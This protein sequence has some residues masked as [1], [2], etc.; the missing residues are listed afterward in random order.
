MTDENSAKD[1]TNAIEQAMGM[2][3]AADH[4]VMV[5]MPRNMG[6]HPD[7]PRGHSSL[8]AR[9]DSV[10]EWDSGRFHLLKAKTVRPRAPSVIIAGIRQ[11]GL[12][13]DGSDLRELESA[14][15]RQDRDHADD[16]RSLWMILYS[17]CS[18]HSSYTLA[19]SAMEDY[20]GD[21]RAVIEQSE[22]PYTKN[23]CFTAII[24]DEK[25]VRR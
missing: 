7:A 1:V 25:G 6:G 4:V 14:F 3:D 21:D 23:V 8:F 2:I 5:I 16:R 13:P 20:P 18:G 10:I 12:A 15:E 24:L 11:F 9:A 19:R 17:L 22:D